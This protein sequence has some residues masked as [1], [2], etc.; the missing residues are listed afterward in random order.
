M[1]DALDHRGG[2]SDF[3]RVIARKVTPLT[4]DSIQTE[5]SGDIQQLFEP[6][7]AEGGPYAHPVICLSV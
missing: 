7:A 4:F 5:I 2:S 1:Q 6:W 3:L